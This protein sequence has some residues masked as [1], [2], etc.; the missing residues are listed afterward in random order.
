MSWVGS[1]LSNDN[2]IDYDASRPHPS[3]S[4]F[5]IRNLV[6]FSISCVLVY[7]ILP[8]ASAFVPIGKIGVVPE[9]GRNIEVVRSGLLNSP[10]VKKVYIREG[11]SLTVSFEAPR[12]IRLRLT[13]MRCNSSLLL[14]PWTC[15]DP[16]AQIM[17][18]NHARSG[19]R[20]IKNPQ[21]GFYY[22]QDE[23]FLNRAPHKDYDLVW[24]R[25]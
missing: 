13:L 3:N 22:F 8:Y 11:Q 14:A 19:S 17:D 2:H 18:I 7:A 6:K 21:P 25:D 24:T 1:N 10:T 23:A 20:S 15:R 16:Q 12:Q 4:K 5:I 9:L